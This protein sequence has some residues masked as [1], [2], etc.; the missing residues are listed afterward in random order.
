MQLVAPGLC[1]VFTACF[2]V[3]PEIR[4]YTFAVFRGPL[5]TSVLCYFPPCSNLTFVWFLHVRNSPITLPC[6]FFGRAHGSAVRL[7]GGPLLPSFP[8]LSLCP[9]PVCGS[10]LPEFFVSHW[11][12]AQFCFKRS[13][14]RRRSLFFFS[15]C[16]QDRPNGLS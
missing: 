1:C 7:E 11:V 6:R 3:P 16:P 15:F 2:L 9:S 12:R 13:G 14:F 4:I 10:G 8:R 5:V